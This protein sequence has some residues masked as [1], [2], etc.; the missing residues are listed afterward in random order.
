MGTDV[1]TQARRACLRR[2]RIQLKGVVLSGVRRRWAT[3]LRHLLRAHP[4]DRPRPATRTLNPLGRCDAGAST[5]A[6]AC[7]GL[8]Q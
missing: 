4:L 1:K 5:L 7:D 2:R 6:S 3:G 8:Q